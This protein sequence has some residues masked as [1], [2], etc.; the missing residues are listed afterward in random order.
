[1]NGVINVKITT[2]TVNSQEFCDFIE[3]YLQ[4]QLLPFNGTNPKSWTMLPYIT[5]SR[6]Y[7]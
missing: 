1:M 3:R 7:T 5:H 4:P 2:E 6:P